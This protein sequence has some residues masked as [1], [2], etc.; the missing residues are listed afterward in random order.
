MFSTIQRVLVIYD[1]SYLSKT[2]KLP[3][4]VLVSLQDYL[5]VSF[6]CR[7]ARMDLSRNLC[8]PLLGLCNRYVILKNDLIW[9]EMF[10]TCYNYI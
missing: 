6:I 7:F 3:E 5:S 10:E 9:A 8:L 2:A 4:N 1:N